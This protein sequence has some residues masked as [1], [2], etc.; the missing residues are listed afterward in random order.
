MILLV[1][2]LRQTYWNFACFKE[3]KEIITQDNLKLP[4]FFVSIFEIR[5]QG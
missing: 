5:I 4:G 3:G 1:A 2:L